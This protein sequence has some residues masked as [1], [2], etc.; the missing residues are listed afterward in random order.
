MKKLE[1]TLVDMTCGACGGKG[2]VRKVFF[3]TDCPVCGGTGKVDKTYSIKDI[4]MG[5][6]PYLTM[7]AERAESLRTDV[8][9]LPVACEAIAELF[10]NQFTPDDVKLHMGVSQINAMFIAIRDEKNG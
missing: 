2:K 7:L 4:M 10:G 9:A 5:K 8:E 1:I 3:K 6:V